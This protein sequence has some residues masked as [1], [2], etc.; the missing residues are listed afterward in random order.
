MQQPLTLLALNVNEAFSESTNFAKAISRLPEVDRKAVLRF[1]FEKDKRLALGSQLLRRYYFARYCSKDWRSCQ[2]GA[3]TKHGK[4]KLLNADR[5][6]DFNISHHG[7][8]VVL[9]A[10]D[11]ADLHVGIDIV[12]LDDFEESVLNLVKTFGPQLATDEVDMIMKS[13][14]PFETFYSFWALK[15]SFIKGLGIGLAVDV[16]NLNFG[17]NE[18]SSIRVQPA[19]KGSWGF[20]LDWLDTESLVAVCCGY[21]AENATLDDDLQRFCQ[22]T[23]TIGSRYNPGRPCC[24]TKV[25]IDEINNLFA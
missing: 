18:S 23:Q 20:R 9:A 10:T 1:K 13:P 5:W 16:K 6:Y 12:C 4:P 14:H 17:K 8:W 2:F 11:R 7:N 25:E 15:E 19:P 24:Y 3:A 22:G 21:T